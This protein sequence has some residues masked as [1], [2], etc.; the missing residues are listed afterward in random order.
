M[1]HLQPNKN[2]SKKHWK[3]VLELPIKKEQSSPFLLLNLQHKF[4]NALVFKKLKMNWA[5]I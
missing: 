3:L 1:Q 5:E 2:C 4:F